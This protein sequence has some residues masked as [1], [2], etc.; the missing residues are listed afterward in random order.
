ME[1]PGQCAGWVWTAHRELFHCRRYSYLP[2]TGSREEWE[3]TIAGQGYRRSG[4]K[5]PAEGVG[6]GR[7]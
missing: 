4:L 7:V 5:V 3:R 6:G 2:R 1:E